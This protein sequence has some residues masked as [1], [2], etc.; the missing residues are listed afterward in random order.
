MDPEKMSLEE[1]NLEE[2][3][4]RHDWRE[5]LRGIVEKEDMDPWDIKLSR[6]IQE[7]I[8]TI[9][10]LQKMDF[11]IP[12]NA[13][14]ASSIL[15]RKKSSSWKLKE[16]EEEGEFI[17]WEEIPTT[18]DQIPPAREEIPEPKPQKR[19]TR[20]KVSVE[21]LID[22]VEDVIDKEKQKAREK[23]KEEKT[24]AQEI[25]PDHLLEIAKRNTRDFEEKTEEL[26]QKI[27]EQIDEENLTT[28]T[29]LIEEDQ[30]QTEREIVKILIPL[31]HLANQG[32]I[33]I[34]QEEVFGEIFV[35][36]PGEKEE[37]EK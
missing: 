19:K 36:Y 11:K 1:M 37:G 7:Y 33:S 2:I 8:Q 25:V 31:L 14:L 3:A 13:L 22:A 32:R 6:L 20:R 24:P 21:E 34:W 23:V 30:D 9:K 15:L 17:Y 4:Q 29:G 12:A 10:Q 35:H 28:F 16:D 27:Q 26:E 5:I 18:P